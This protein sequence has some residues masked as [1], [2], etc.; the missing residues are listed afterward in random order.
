MIGRVT[1]TVGFGLVGGPSRCSIRAAWVYMS[2]VDLRQEGPSVRAR[3]GK[4]EGW[5][6]GMIMEQ[7]CLS[8]DC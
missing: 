6:K 2:S 8:V 1:G 5:G 3:E 4:R 7:Y